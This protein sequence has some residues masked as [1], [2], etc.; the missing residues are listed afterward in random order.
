MRGD[1][2]ADITLVDRAGIGAAVTGT[3]VAL[4]DGKVVAVDLGDDTHMICGTAEIAR[5]GVRPAANDRV[6]R[7]ES[8][9]RRRR[10]YCTA[11]AL[12]TGLRRDFK[13]QKLE[14]LDTIM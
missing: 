13:G 5:A 11:L 3:G 1:I 12:N 9:G 7:R 8:H 6:R 4:D 14:L 10:R 2:A